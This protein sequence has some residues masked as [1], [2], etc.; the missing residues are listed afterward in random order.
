MAD[1]PK[2]IST[3]HNTEVSPVPTVE[4]KVHDSEL[5][6]ETMTRK[7]LMNPTDNT[8]RAKIRASDIKVTTV[9]KLINEFYNFRSK[10][11]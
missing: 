1:Q 9:K 11:G 2:V 6:I 3:I 7:N 4:L 8:G 5:P 10:F